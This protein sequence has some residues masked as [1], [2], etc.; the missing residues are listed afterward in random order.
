MPVRDSCGAYTAPAR[1]MPV[2]AAALLLRPSVAR[3]SLMF[4]RGPRRHLDDQ[5]A[6]RVSLAAFVP[7]L[8]GLLH[9]ED[10]ADDHLELAGI[11]QLHDARHQFRVRRAAAAIGRGAADLRHATEDL[12]GHSDDGYQYAAF[13]HHADRTIIGLL[14]RGVEHQVDVLHYLLEFPGAVVDDL[15]GADGLKELEVVSRGGADDTCTGG[16]GYLHGGRA[17]SPG[18]AMDQHGLTFPDAARL[19]QRT[20]RGFRRDRDARGFF[21]GHGLRLARET[22]DR[23]HRVL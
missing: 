20:E 16:L 15:V 21:E 18:G 2:P 17:H 19:V 3:A 7:G 8:P 9:R 4:H 22:V 12:V 11:G 6:A 13:A 1:V 5:F 23:N 14:V 10:T